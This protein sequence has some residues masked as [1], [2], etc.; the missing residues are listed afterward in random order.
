MKQPLS[1]YLHIPFCQR[2]CH[3][4]DFNTYA[5]LAHLIPPYLEALIR[6]MAN[7]SA[8][9]QEWEVR[10]VFFGGGTPSLLTGQQV[11]QVLDCCR[12]QVAF[13]T[14]V[15]ISLE[16]NPGT[17]DGAKLEG[18]R[19]AG[20]NRLSFG[21]QSFDP[22]E[23]RWLGRIHDRD[24]IGGAVGMA[25]AAGFGRINLDLIYGLPRQSTARW[26]E[27]LRN[28]LELAPDHLSLYALSVEEGTPLA[29]WVRQGK[30]PEPDPDLAADHYLAASETLEAA[31][32]RQYEIS[33]WARP[34]QECRHNLTYWRNQPYLGL[35]AGAHSCFGG[36]R[37]HNVLLPQEYMRRLRDKE[38]AL[39]LRSGQ[40]TGNEEMSGHIE[41]CATIPA[42]EAIRR[43]SPLA[44][45]EAIAAETDLSDTLILGLRLAEGVRL[46]EVAARHG[47]EVWE[48]Y[49]DAIRELGDLGLLEAAGDCLKLTPRGRLL[50]N[51]VFLRFLPQGRRG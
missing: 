5:G 28:A 19:A 2:K 12:Q 44:G 6:E 13:A 50:A 45:I 16:A 29:D 41:L 37:F 34:G 30:T 18:Y 17:V 15:E 21:A 10:T 14:E 32:Y 3:Y 22:A 51:E 7:W 27:S 40:G 46:S 1:L 4:C 24:E 35:G 36:Y 25:R 33:N 8:L 9:L 23:L 42:A 20:V 48:R 38:Q 43:A 49:G 47:V 31:G 11:R 26:R 39:R